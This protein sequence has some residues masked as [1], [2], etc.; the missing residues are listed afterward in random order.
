MSREAT[1]Q[2]VEDFLATPHDELQ[3]GWANKVL[4]AADEARFWVTED[5][6]NIIGLGI[7][8]KFSTEHA[9]PV[10]WWIPLVWTDPAYRHDHYA[11]EMAE[12]GI[13]SLAAEGH[14]FRWKDCMGLDLCGGRCTPYVAS[15]DRSP[16]NVP[17]G[18]GTGGYLPTSRPFRLLDHNHTQGFI[19][20]VVT[21]E[22][23]IDWE[24]T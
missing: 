12:A 1:R 18:P 11:W 15:I 19:L 4:E 3:T 10:G 2:E 5:G 23:D 6:G 17:Y 13:A 8:A 16:D 9:D 22:I 14:T 7:L 24:P 21:D 20:H